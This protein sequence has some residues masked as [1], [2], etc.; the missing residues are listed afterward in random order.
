MTLPDYWRANSNSIASGGDLEQVNYCTNPDPIHAASSIPTGWTLSATTGHTVTWSNGAVHDGITSKHFKCVYNGGAGTS[1]G[2]SVDPAAAGSVVP[3]Q[4]ITVAAVLGQANMVGCTVRFTV[5]WYT[6]ADDLISKSTGGDIN[7]GAGFAQAV[8]S[9]T[10]PAT[11]DKFVVYLAA[12]GFAAGSTVEFSVCE[13]VLLAGVD[14]AP[15][16]WNGDYPNCHWASARDASVSHK[17]LVRPNGGK[18]SIEATTDRLRTGAWSPGIPVIAGTDYGVS[19]LCEVARCVGGTFS[20]DVVWYTADDVYIDGATISGWLAAFSFETAYSDVVTA[21]ATA[22][23][24]LLRFWWSSATTPTG[25]CVAHVRGISFGK[26]VLK[27]PAV[28]SLAAQTGQYAAPLDLLLDAAAVTLAACYV[29]HTED[30][31]AVIGDFVKPMVAAA[32]LK[33]G[34]GAATGVVLADEAG[35]PAGGTSVWE[36]KDA[37]GDTTLV[38]VTAHSGEYAVF[39][40][41]KYRVGAAGVYVRQQF[42]DWRPITTAA[43]KL[44]YLGNVSLP[45]QA[46]RG[47]GVSTLAVSIKGDD[48]NYAGI[49]YVALLPVS[50]GL[51]GWQATTGHAHR[52]L[53]ADGTMFVEDVVKLDEAF[54]GS[55]PL[56]VLRGQ[57][58][59]LAEQ[60]TAA[61]TTIVSTTLTVVPRY[62]QFP[63]A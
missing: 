16:Y 53:W 14:V 1:P 17:H 5:S 8:Y 20:C 33:T 36:T 26:S 49:N 35:Y 60:A 62:E 2:F 22:T 28:A 43:L 27:A 63:T 37:A 39:A 44:L 12:G 25:D 50:R 47:A 19:L 38:D 57:L 59:I 9:P 21:P 40:N 42:G 15:Y 54:G 48:T 7:P 4:T 10:A 55:A 52:V 13:V 29:G 61:P 46:V 45:T 30:E 6:S 23:Q 34:G 24:A 58:V 31:T 51:I 18:L 3:G 56:R 11:A 32:W 41:V